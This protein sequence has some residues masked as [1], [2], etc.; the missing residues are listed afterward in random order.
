MLIQIQ[1]FCSV[2]LNSISQLKYKK[3]FFLA[4]NALISPQER[5]PVALPDTIHDTRVW[6]AKKYHPQR[7]KYTLMG[8]SGPSMDHLLVGVAYSTDHAKYVV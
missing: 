8:V 5:N 2:N 3:I 4:K 6:G 1:I 7:L